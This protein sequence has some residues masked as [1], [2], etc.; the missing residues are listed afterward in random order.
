MKYIDSLLSLLI[1][2]VQKIGI[3]RLSVSL[4]MIIFWKQRSHYWF[5]LIKDVINEDHF[6]CV[7][8]R[9]VMENF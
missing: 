5:I 9:K 3:Y 8:S 1:L 4:D 7:I 6:Y 2:D